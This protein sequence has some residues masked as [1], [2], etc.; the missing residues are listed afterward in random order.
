MKEK[1]TYTQEKALKNKKLFQ[2]KED[3]LMNKRKDLNKAIQHVKK[4]RGTI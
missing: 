3:E 1:Q 2:D 4:Q